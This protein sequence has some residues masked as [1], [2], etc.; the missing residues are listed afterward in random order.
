MKAGTRNGNSMRAIAMSL[1]IAILSAAAA[2]AQEQPSQVSGNEPGGGPGPAAR[3]AKP[4]RA[5]KLVS[6][7]LRMIQAPRLDVDEV[8]RE[9]GG[10]AH[11]FL[12][13]EKT[14]GAI[15]AMVT[16]KKARVV[17]QLQAVSK[18]GQNTEIKSVREIVCPTGYEVQS[19]RDRNVKTTNV[20]D[21]DDIE[22]AEDIMVP[23]NFERREV[24]TILSV[25]PVVDP[26]GTTIDLTLIPQRVRV[27]LHP[28][29]PAAGRAGVGHGLEQPVFSTESYATSMVAPSGKP[30]LLGVCDVIED[31][32]GSGKAGENIILWILTATVVSLNP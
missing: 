30:L 29:K 24:G 27:S 22:A 17:G 28:D 23:G 11:T 6:I 9:S 4:Q 26:T 2:S 10:I 31:Q 13:N 25:S 1:G 32:D 7:E 19:W 14:L 12:I 16:G 3:P 8:F 21:T 18:S 5:P 20:V 15:N